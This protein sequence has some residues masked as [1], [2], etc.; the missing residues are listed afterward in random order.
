MQN[1]ESMN[2]FA[3]PQPEWLAWKNTTHAPLW[4]AVALSCEIDPSS[5]ALPS[6]SKSL[7]PL[8][9]HVPGGFHARLDAARSAIAAERL[10]VRQFVDATHS[11]VELAAFAKWASAIGIALPAQFPQLNTL[12]EALHIT[13]WPWG[14]YD[15]KLLRVLAEAANKFWKHYDPTD[16]GTAP[17]NA[18]IISWLTGS[19]GIAKR[20]AE[21]MATILRADGLAP[22]PRP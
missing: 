18:E 16:P 4:Q 19:R 1:P 9:G 13:G 2:P 14:Q 15:T 5:L 10:K 11:E 6:T 22:G 8:L 3:L 20:T 17:T 12:D 21:V 7:S